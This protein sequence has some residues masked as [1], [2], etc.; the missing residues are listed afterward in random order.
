MMVNFMRR[1]LYHGS[2]LAICCLAG[3]SASIVSDDGPGFGLAESGGGQV[4]RALDEPRLI[5]APQRAT[6]RAPEPDR[7]V[8]FDYRGGRD[9][10]TG[11]AA[12]TEGA[13]DRPAA[14]TDVTVRPVKPVSAPGRSL[15]AAALAPP[16]PR[17]AG[18]AAV[19]AAVRAEA[20]V[21][22][23]DTLH[24]LSVRHKVSVKAI[25]AANNLTSSKIF[26]GQKLV[27]PSATP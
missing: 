19:S 17:A 9:P 23:G 16:Q 5:A 4:Q 21:A 27:I 24:G 15:T 7:P 3:C 8:P 10:V 6:P 20:I 2:W 13:G 22:K 14:G 1:I 11:K 12:Q 26:P 25:M 18:P